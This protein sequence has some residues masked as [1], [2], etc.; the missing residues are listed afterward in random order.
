VCFAG[1][2]R[3]IFH[4][5]ISHSANS[6]I[7]VHNHPSGEPTPSESDFRLTRRLSEGARILQVNLLDHVITGRAFGDRPGYFS[8]KEAGLL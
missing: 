8:F 2:P 6:F 7:L 3:D 5:V 1:H 4:P